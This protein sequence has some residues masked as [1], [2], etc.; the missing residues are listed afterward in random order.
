MAK[1][2]PK[3]DESPKFVVKKRVPK[4]KPN[5]FQNIPDIKSRLSHPH[6]LAEVFDFPVSEVEEQ[7]AKI[8]LDSQTLPEVISK[9]EMLGYPNNEILDS[10][11]SGLGY[12]INEDL[13]SQTS[14]NGYP[15]D[16]IL[17][18]QMLQGGYP[19]IEDLAV[20]TEIFG[21]PNI[22]N[23]DSKIAKEPVWIAKNTESLDIIISKEI[24]PDSQKSRKSNS[25]GK[26][27]KYDKKRS[28]ASVFIRADEELIS[29]VKH[30]NVEQKLDMREFFELS[31]R[32]Y[33]D[34][35]GNP[36]TEDL[37]SNIALE[38]RRMMIMFRT[39]PSIINLFREYNRILTP[40]SEW[41]PKDDAVGIK[42]NEIDL[43]IV[44]IGIIVTQTN[45][46][47]NETD[48]Q[49]SRFK[50]Y[51]RE[52]DKMATIGFSPETLDVMIQT[53]RKRW[54][55]LTK[56]TLDL[57]FLNKEEKSV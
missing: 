8:D 40:N 57:S 5:F 13:D 35:F 23:L 44:E 2:Q 41:K 54:S 36:N 14:I 10:Q 38:D 17:D 28:T 30:F 50:Y 27:E 19:N 56:K 11:P 1:K 37:A 7:N 16:Q 42:Y 45:I 15:N 51:T 12:P 48:T 49:V 26:W 3:N 46:I 9:E 20:Q 22:E 18:S 53:Y 33:I 29:E 32:R 6:P 21:Q 34:S 47:E 4:D 31:A 24:V 52:I 25:K 39:K 43:R 55:E